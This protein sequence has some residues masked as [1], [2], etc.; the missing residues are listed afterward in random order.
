MKRLLEEGLEL[1]ED[2]VATDDQGGP[3][4][5]GG[6]MGE[7]LAGISESN[8]GDVTGFGMGFEIAESGIDIRG[9]ESQIGEED[10]WFFLAC[11]REDGGRLGTAQDTVTKVAQAV[12]QLGA[13]QELFVQHERQRLHHV[14]RLR[15]DVTKS[16]GAGKRGWAMKRTLAFRDR[17]FQGD[18]VVNESR[19]KGLR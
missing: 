11:D 9:L 13:G 17:F 15:W 8:D 19:R 7:I 2:S 14:G 16:K 18:E 4:F 10:D 5:S 12:K 3:G 1:I 6:G